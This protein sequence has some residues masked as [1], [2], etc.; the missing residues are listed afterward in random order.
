MNKAIVDILAKVNNLN[1]SPKIDKAIKEQGLAIDGDD[2]HISTEI[3]VQGN[4][5]KV[6][7]GSSISGRIFAETDVT[8]LTAM[9]CNYDDHPTIKDD[10]EKRIIDTFINLIKCIDKEAFLCHH[11]SIK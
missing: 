10:F 3:L 11:N 4:F 9:F 5:F 2:Y 6:A 7:V 8:Y 1:E